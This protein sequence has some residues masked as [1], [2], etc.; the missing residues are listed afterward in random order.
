MVDYLSDSSGDESDEESGSDADKEEGSSSGARGRLPVAP[1][2]KRRKLDVPIREQRRQ[3][4][5]KRI[6]EFQSA[7]DDIQKH[8][9]SR[10]TVFDSGPN[11]LQEYRARAIQSYLLMVVKRGR[12]T[13]DA[14][15]RAA[16][17]QG[18]AAKWGGRSVR[19]W[20]RVWIKER[21][22]PTSQKGRH[23]K[24]YSLLDDPAIKAELR[25]FVRSKKWSMDPVKLAQFT[26]GT[27]LPAAAD[28]YLRQ[29]TTDEMPHGLKK[30][31]ELE[32]F[33]RLQLKVGSKSIFLSTARLQANDMVGKTWVFE[34][35][36]VLRKK[37][38]GRGL[39]RSDIICSTCGHIPEA[40]EELEYGKNYDGYWTGELFCKQLRKKIIPAFVKRHGPGY[41][42]LFVVDNS[43][44]HSAYAVDALLV[45]RMNTKPGGKQARM[46]PGWFMRNNERV[47]QLMIFPADHP[48]FPDQPKG[49]KQYLRENCDYTFD[50]L[51][52]NMPKALAAVQL[53][54]IRR[55]EHRMHRWMDAYR[56]GMETQEAQ[57]QVRAFSSKK[58]KSHRRIPEGVARAFDQ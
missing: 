48:D 2:L 54:T 17:S 18:F 15:E 14:S 10:K 12:L 38:V 20:T 45:S 8:I 22:L 55:W 40:G 16:E 25:T 41:Q 23:A 46:R 35:Q 37:G 42:A 11:S 24:A 32:L 4:Q 33:P 50:T 53:A 47:V 5:A 44:G 31:M 34:D 49:M 27:L 19:K 1:P 57:L 9:K 21:K 51:K 58:Y 52:E 3:K 30:Y 56:S 43:Q 6:E 28:K 39:H 26:Q 13:V 7:A 36:H 29:I